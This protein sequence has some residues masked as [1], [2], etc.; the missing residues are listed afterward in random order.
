MKEI[1][2]KH[3]KFV[4][5][6]DSEIKRLVLENESLYQRIKKLEIEKESL[7]KRAGELE[8]VNFD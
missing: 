4:K 7:E 5:E 8:D 6:K 1:E 2:C 3:N